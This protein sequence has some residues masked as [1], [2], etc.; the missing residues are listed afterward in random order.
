MNIAGSKLIKKNGIIISWKGQ[1]LSYIYITGNRFTVWKPRFLEYNHCHA[2]MTKNFKMCKTFYFHIQTKLCCP[3]SAHPVFC[4]DHT[5]CF[6][7]LL[8]IF[9]FDLHR[10]KNSEISWDQCLKIS[11]NI[12][13]I[14]F[15]GYFN[16][17]WEAFLWGLLYSD[18]LGR[19]WGRKLNCGWGRFSFCFVNFHQSLVL[20]AH[21]L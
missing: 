19:I 17:F 3:R 10:D 9:S 4:F 16:G 7:V 12:S 14:W 5:Y 13:M 8:L 1:V 21:Y 20:Q 11:Q 15:L 18:G 6:S 2:L